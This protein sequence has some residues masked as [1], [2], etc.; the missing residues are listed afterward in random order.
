MTDAHAGKTREPLVHLT[1]RDYMN[2]LQAWGIR[3]AAVLRKK[4]SRREDQQGEE[5]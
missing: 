1:R 3:L 2:P 4:A 5:E